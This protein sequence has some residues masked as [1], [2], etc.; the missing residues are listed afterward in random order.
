MVNNRG[1]TKNEQ[2]RQTMLAYIKGLLEEKGED[3]IV[4]ESGG[5]GYL[6][7]VPGSVLSEL[8]SIGEP[9]KIYTY[10]HV[11]EDAMVLFGFLTKEDRETFK[12]LI[13]VN[14]IGPK[15]AMGIL[16]VLSTYDLKV[17]IMNNDVTR[18]T[19][20]PGVGKK[21][22]Q[23]LILDLKDKL[24]IDDYSELLTAQINGSD[25]TASISVMDEAVEALVS[26]GYSSHEAIH[27][28]KGMNHLTTVEDI[29]KGALKSLAIF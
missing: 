25:G 6:I 19:R 10:L 16:S 23:K 9:V 7:L 1:S 8:P 5:I 27:A 21:T 13:T 22:A 2:E 11:R 18:I 12:L 14:G 28:V 17:A 4:V 29:I 20:A 15:G 3:H 24:K 26:L